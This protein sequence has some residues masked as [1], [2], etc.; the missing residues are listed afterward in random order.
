MNE[1]NNLNTN[2]WTKQ[3]NHEY[4]TNMNETKT[5]NNREETPTYG[6]VFLNGE[7]IHNLNNIEHYKQAHLGLKKHKHKHKYKQKNT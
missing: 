7:S 6:D 3:N 1:R 5:N 2:E 4:K